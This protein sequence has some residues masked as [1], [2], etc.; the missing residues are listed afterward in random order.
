MSYDN[1]EINPSYIYDGVTHFIKQFFRN[2]TGPAII[3]ISGG[4]D[5]TICAALLAK[6]LGKDRVW[7]ISIPN[8]YQQDIDDAKHV[9]DILGIHKKIVNIK[10]AFNAL[11]NSIEHEL[12]GNRERLPASYMSNTPA[13]LR[14]VTLYGFANSLGGYVCNTC[15]LSE[16]IVGW[17]TYGGDGFGD[18]SPLGLLTVSEVLALG[19]YLK[20]PS[21][22]VHKTPSDGMC[23]QSDEEKFGF[24][25]EV[26]DAMI[27]DQSHEALAP[28]FDKI[29]EMN[30]KAHFKHENIHI[31]TY[32]P[33]FKIFS[34][35]KWD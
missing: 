9:C 16:S 14:M 35:F 17:E 18:F 21:Q 20:L 11:T 3:G 24:T 32:D 26:L 22:L 31:P 33:R 19:D 7:G 25:Y 30:T 34:G 12:N 13:R 4:K 8:G 27:R 15:N 1:Y 23:G 2:K 28:V 29:L 10:D 6:V 5:S